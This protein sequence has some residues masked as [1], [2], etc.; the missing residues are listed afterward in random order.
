MPAEVATRIRPWLV[1]MLLAI[2]E[3][4]RHRQA[5]GKQALDLQLMDEALKRGVPVT[6]LETIESQLAMLAAIPEDQQV[7]MLKAMLHYADRT[8]DQM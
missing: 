1:F 4:E 2:P 7:A 5:A 3:C 8:E 6:G